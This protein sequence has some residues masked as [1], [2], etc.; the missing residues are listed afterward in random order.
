MIA[1]MLC[2]IF[3]P[4]THICHLGFFLFFFYSSSVYIVSLALLGFTSKTEIL[5]TVFYTEMRVLQQWCCNWEM[6]VK[7]TG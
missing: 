2:D 6:G 3:C 7:E 5:V 4:L 1:V